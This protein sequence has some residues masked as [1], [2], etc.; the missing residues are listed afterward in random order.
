M[1]TGPVFSSSFFQWL[2]SWKGIPY[3]RTQLHLIVSSVDHSLQSVVVATGS[4]NASSTHR[5]RCASSW[6]QFI[7]SAHS[8]VFLIPHSSSLSTLGHLIMQFDTM[9][10]LKTFQSRI[11][12]EPRPFATESLETLADDKKL[13][14]KAVRK[15]DKDLLPPMALFYALAVGNARI[16]TAWA[17][18]RMTD[19]QY[20]IC[21]TVL[22]AYVR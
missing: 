6:F 2:S 19:R 5:S 12:E 11:I 9:P 15:I 14:K 13:G 8:V 7:T 1:V 4:N 16:A 17:H 22:F 3:C 21:L 10:R 18:L 20:Q